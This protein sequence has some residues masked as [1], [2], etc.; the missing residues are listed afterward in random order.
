MESHPA[1]RPGGRAFPVR[2]LSLTLLI[3]LSLW[4][5]GGCAL[6]KLREDVKL[7]RDA[8]LII[9]E[10]VAHAP[11]KKP[12]VVVAY[13]RQG[14]QIVI[15][16]YA[17]LSAPG[18]YELLVQE[19]RYQLFA[20]EDANGNLAHDK[21]EHAGHFGKAENVV[22]QWGGIVWGMDIEIS[23]QPAGPVPFLADLLLL[24]SDGKR[25]PFTSA[26]F[27][28]D[29][30]NPIF[31]AEQGA[32]GFW[33]PL[34][35]FRRTG[36]NVYFLEPYD[37]RKIPV[38]LV[39]GAAGSPQDW[40]YFI[41]N[42]DRSRYQPWIFHYPSGAR[43]QTMSFFLRK[44]LYDL[45]R[46]YRF[47]H[48]FI[49]AHSMGGLVSRA[50]LIEF[51]QHNRSVKLFVSIST[52]WGGE[53]RAKTGVE[54]SPA[55]IPSWKDME[56]DSPFIRNVFSV[57]L[58]D[59]M[60]YYLLFGHKGGGSLFRQNNDSTVTLESMLDPRAQAD[61]LKV[62]GFNEDHISILNSPEVIAYYK[63]LANTAAANLD[64]AMMSTRGYVHVRHGFSPPDV[65]IPLQMTFVLAP[66]A[67][68]EGE[69]QL[70]INPFVPLQETEDVA[71]GLY[72]ASLC[73]LGFKTDPAN[74]PVS[75]QAGKI[76]EVSYTLSPQG[77]VAGVITATTAPEDSYW[78][79]IQTLS[80]KI[81]VSAIHLTGAGIERKLSPSDGMSDREVLRTFLASKDYAHKNQFAFFDLPAGDYTLS[82]QAEGCETYTTELK[83]QP[84]EFVPPPPFRLTAK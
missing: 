54:H 30:D 35:S 66:G 44:K 12:I 20:F 57:K 50:A 48:L 75:V 58:P 38:L 51:D 84:G 82:I 17:V 27:I 5:L 8:C 46:K 6:I 22:T 72:E 34:D 41:E 60:R 45:E 23:D 52:P 83:V 70:K 16:D 18:Q 3:F 21:G 74:H 39:H 19:G 11:L 40:R 15:G 68:E 67:P 62:A 10:I 76:A 61:A 37:R 1:G 78:G 59:T 63:T 28:T 24:Y 32:K 9:G 26:G 43:L 4:L 65:K 80:E 29:L 71:P 69:T 55:V 47:E 73:A 36:A 79:Y 13:T 2:G 7:S 53:E 33:A 42:M 49:V 64:K 77:M 31:T 14:D 25:K 81:K 56:P